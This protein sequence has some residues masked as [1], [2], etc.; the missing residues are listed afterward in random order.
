MITCIYIDI[1]LFEQLSAV[2]CTP[3]TSLSQALQTLTKFE[4]DHISTMKEKRRNKLPPNLVNCRSQKCHTTW[5]LPL[6][7]CDKLW[8]AYSFFLMGAKF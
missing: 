1:L 2:E 6:S 3:K 4:S 7:M 8:L 5:P